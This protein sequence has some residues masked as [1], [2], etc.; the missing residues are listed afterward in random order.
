MERLQSLF[1]I[2]SASIFEFVK[3]SQHLPRLFFC[4]YTKYFLNKIYGWNHYLFPWSAI[5]VIKT[6]DFAINKASDW[7][8]ILSQISCSIRNRYGKTSFWQNLIFVT[9]PEVSWVAENTIFH[10][11]DRKI[12][13]F[14]G[15]KK[16][17]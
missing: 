9:D 11:L 7:K 8:Q 15:W 12:T 4:F 16:P 2:L 1:D 5:T 6:V 14:L 10:V 13:R 17:C 3:S